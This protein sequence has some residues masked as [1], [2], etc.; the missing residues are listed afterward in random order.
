MVGRYVYPEPILALYSPSFT[1]TFLQKQATTTITM[2]TESRLTR[3]DALLG[4]AVAAGAFLLSAG[5]VATPAGPAW[6]E[7]TPSQRKQQY[8]RYAPRIKSK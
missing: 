8:F 5:V 6:A 3:R 7:F 4:G 2:K 1:H